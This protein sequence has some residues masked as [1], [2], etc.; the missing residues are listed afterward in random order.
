MRALVDVTRTVV[1][2]GVV[3]L[4]VAVPVRGQQVEIPGPNLRETMRAFGQ[5]AGSVALGD[6]LAYGP[7]LELATAPLGSATGGFSVIFDPAT[8][9]FARGAETFGPA[10]AQR[11]LTTGRGKA[12]F[13]ATYQYVKFD[14]LA[15]TDLDAI[16]AFKSNGFF[17]IIPTQS[18]LSFDIRSSTVS[19]FS[20]VGITNRIDIGVVVPITSIS[21]EGEITQFFAV[22]PNGFDSA[23]QSASGIAD[24]ALQGK[25]QLWKSQKTAGA[26]AT[27][28]TSLAAVVTVRLPT[29]AEEDLLGLGFARTKVSAV[30]SQHAPRFAIHGNFGYEFWADQIRF[31]QDILESEFAETDGAMELAIGTEFA[32]SSRF[33]LNL[34]LLAQQI[35][36]AGKLGIAPFE[37]PP[38][39]TAQTVVGLEEGLQKVTLVPGFRWNV[40]GQALLNANVLVSLKNDGLRAKFTPSVGFDWT[41]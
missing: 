24:I 5:G 15:N 39:L 29:G 36:G 4:T 18:D 31:A 7:A 19:L 6:A 9:A 10:F 27:P 20:T 32:A 8:G 21:V 3:A 1:A 25:V 28:A 17:N 13:G 38:I 37:I 12:S 40:F 16:V 2:A 41:F 26:T 35:R 14:Q 11:A 34:D 33:T 22:G 23:D 30:F